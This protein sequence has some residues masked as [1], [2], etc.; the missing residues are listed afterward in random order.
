MINQ[1]K[2]TMKIQDYPNIPQ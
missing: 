1:E 2:N